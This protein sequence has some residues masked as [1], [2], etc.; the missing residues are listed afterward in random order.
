M[1]RI[2][3]VFGSFRYA[4]MTDWG[5]L[6][7]SL[8]RIDMDGA[9]F[10]RIVNVSII[11]PYGIS[12]DFTT[13]RVYW[14]DN[15]LEYIRSVDYDG[16]YK[17]I[18]IAYGHNVKSL[19]SLT[20]FENYLY[21]T[22]YFKNSVL[23]VSKRNGSAIKSF[24][25][26]DFMRAY[27]IKVFHRQR[28]PSVKHPCS[29]KNGNCAH[30]CLISYDYA[31]HS[32]IAKC[33]CKD[34]FKLG[35]DGRSCFEALQFPFLLFGGTHPGTIMG[36]PVEPPMA[37]F[38]TLQPVRNLVRPTAIGLLVN[39][40]DI[41]FSDAANFTIQKENLYSHNRQMVIGAGCHVMPDGSY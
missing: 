8:L 11:Y 7:P 34:G 10:K 36:I 29:V 22:D 4:F 3:D 25:Q 32:P 18:T 21:A 14:L 26:R 15:Y 6:Q 30:I 28:Q 24:V 27:S 2:S 41:Y 23:R 38:Q 13:R 5:S 31:S 39:K 9:N 20:L 35:D 33:I 40:S 1:N 37:G 17:P 16:K 12:L 19:H